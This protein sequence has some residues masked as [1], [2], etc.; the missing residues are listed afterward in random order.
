[1]KEQGE[2]ECLFEGKMTWLQKGTRLTEDNF[3]LLSEV[4][5]MES[6]LIGLFCF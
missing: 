4:K 1:M 5:D 6:S 3:L 2:K